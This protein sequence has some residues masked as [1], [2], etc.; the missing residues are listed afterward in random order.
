MTAVITC[1][2]IT[3]CFLIRRHYRAVRENLRRLDDL[4]TTVPVVPATK[5]AIAPQID[6]NAPTAAVMVGGFS[7]FGL[8]QLMSIHMQFP[9]YYRNF[10]FL[11]V[12]VLDSG[13]FKGSE[14]VK[15][16]EEET[17]AH[18]KQ[19]VEWCRLNGWAA[20]YRMSVDTEA[21]SGLEKLCRKVKDEFPHATF[22]SGKLIFQNEKTYHRL[23]H[24]QIP[25]AIQRRLHFAG[26][27]VIV[28]PIRVLENSAVPAF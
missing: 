24:Y 27:P 4:L 15:K 14:G 9:N 1:T 5:N 17:E 11:S 2:I 18:L 7:G 6:K 12:G 3:L 28:L 8:H 16:M 21:V 10:I 23:L 19:Y 22:F 25:Y 20:D 13:N 26:L